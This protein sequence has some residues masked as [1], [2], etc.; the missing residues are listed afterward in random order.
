[1][2]NTAIRGLFVAPVTPFTADAGAVD[3]T[4]L[5]ALVSELVDAGV[6]GLMPNGSTGENTA[7]SVD[8]RREVIETVVAAAKG[9]VPVFAGSGVADTAT[10]IA[11]SQQ[12]IRAGATGVMVIVPYY[13]RPSQAGIEA[14]IVAVARAVDAPVM[15]YN[16]PDRTVVR[17]E[18]ETLERICAVAENVTAVKES[19]PG[20]DG[21][22][23]FVRALGDRVSVLAGEDGD[24]VPM[25]Q[26]GAV[27]AAS[28][29]ANL[30]PRSVG[31]M[32]R[33][34]LAGDFDAAR[35]DQDR[36]AALRDAAFCEPL[37]VPV[38]TGLQL[39]GL[40]EDSVRLPLLRSAEATRERLEAV[41]A[42][43]PLEV[44]SRG[45]RIPS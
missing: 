20:G 16:N 1:M 21:V 17:L 7:L 37:P 41:L 3:Y 32:L 6:H 24:V 27:G 28:V 14:H 35:R 9:R 36:L 42:E 19:T 29:V 12:A 39:G 4:G 40:I 31:Q 30:V 34:C 2:T 43:T 18:V 26:A 33:R 15:I 8:E 45:P 11:L 22:A 5:E 44:G 10:T 38:K 25:V 13:V 23:A